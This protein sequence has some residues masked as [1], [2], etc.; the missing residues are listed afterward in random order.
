MGPMVVGTNRGQI[1]PEEEGREIQIR[2]LLDTIPLASHV[3]VGHVVA[4]QVGEVTQ[5]FCAL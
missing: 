3:V 2:D 4:E 1:A 5:V